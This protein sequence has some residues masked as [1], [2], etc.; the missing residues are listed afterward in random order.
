MEVGVYE[1][2]EVLYGGFVGVVDLFFECGCVVVFEFFWWG[3]VIG[4]DLLVVV[5]VVVDEVEGFFN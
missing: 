4:V 5:V 2:Y 3:F 1:C